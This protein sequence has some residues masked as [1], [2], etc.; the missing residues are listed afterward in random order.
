MGFRVLCHGL[1]QIGF[2]PH[3]GFILLGLQTLVGV[4]AKYQLVAP[5]LVVF[6]AYAEI[7]P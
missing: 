6:L 7:R 4:K 1:V 5:R 3:K 2:Y